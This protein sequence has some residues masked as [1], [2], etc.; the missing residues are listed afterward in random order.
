MNIV[1]VDSSDFTSLLKI[2]EASVRATH[3][4]LSEQGMQNLSP[5]VLTALGQVELSGS[6]DGQGKLCGFIGVV[7]DKIEMLFVHPHH[8]RKGCGKALIEHVERKRKMRYVDVNEQNPQ[9]LVFYQ[10][11]GF[12][13]ASRSACDEQGRAFP[14]LHLERAATAK[15]QAIYK[16]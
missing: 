3:D 7:G 16:K 12:R 13:L 15:A 1:A 10:H 8:F 2:W 11:M 6:V 14:I 4:F 5:D 9:A